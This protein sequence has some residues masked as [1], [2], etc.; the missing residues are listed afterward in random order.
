[1]PPLH[2]ATPVLTHHIDGT[3]VHFKLEALQPVGSF[4]L[5]G[6]G[7][8][9]TLAKAQGARRLVSS[10]GGNAGCAMAYAARALDLPAI[11]YVP[12][13]TSEMMRAKISALGAEVRV[14]GAVWDEADA[15]ARGAATDASTFYVHPFEHPEVWRGHATLI[16]ELRDQI[17][18]PDAIVVSVG[19]GGLLAGVLEG[20]DRV[21]WQE[22]PVL[23]AETQGAASLAAAFI[24][25]RPVTLDAITSLA[26]TLG[27]KRVSDEAFIRARSHAVTPVQMSDADAVR[28]C[29]RFADEARLLVEPACGAALSLVYD[30]AP[31]LADARS[32]AVVVCGGAA[33]DLVMLA[34]HCRALGLAPPFLAA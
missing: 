31:E 23:A 12:S 27:A 25:G 18:R 22:V 29:V 20:M 28:A 32:V 24:A 9:C 8:L 30:R 4:K 34:G 13:T 2:V 21:G 7:R 6:I 15:T 17:E 33:I 10:S 3:V 19:G 11:V 1:M 5:R 14:G 26:V 16:E